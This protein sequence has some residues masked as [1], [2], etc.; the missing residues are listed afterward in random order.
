VRCPLRTDTPSLFIS[1]VQ[2]SDA[3]AEERDVLIKLTLT[4]LSEDFLGS[5]QVA[6]HLNDLQTT[7]RAM[8]LKKIS[9]NLRKVSAF[10]GIQFWCGFSHR[11]T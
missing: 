7:C 6:G 10:S 9:R 5:A 4:K 11:P 1:G 2:E 8:R 3:I